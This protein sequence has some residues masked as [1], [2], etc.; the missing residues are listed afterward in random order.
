VYNIEPFITSM[1]Q[2]LYEWKCVMKNATQHI[3][4]MYVS[5]VA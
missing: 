4:A 1:V 2:I 3:D 5:E